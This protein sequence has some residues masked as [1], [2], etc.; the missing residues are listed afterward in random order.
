MMLVKK[1]QEQLEALSSEPQ[2][3][4]VD[5]FLEQFGS[6]L[7]R[8]AA[9]LKDN[10]YASKFYRLAVS[11]MED[12]VESLEMIQGDIKDNE[13]A[14]KFGLFTNVLKKLKECL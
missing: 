9:V 5:Y 1:L 6:E 11:Q 14:T 12:L 13:L 2:P 4:S 8:V 3:V 10:K 7:K